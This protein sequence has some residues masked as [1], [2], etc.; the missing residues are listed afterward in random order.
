MTT[1]REIKTAFYEWFS[2]ETG[3]QNVFKI[4][5]DADFVAG[6]V[7]SGSFDSESISSLNFETDHQTTLEKLASKIQGLPSV[8]E[9][10]VTGSR[11]ITVTGFEKGNLIDV[12]GPIVTGGL[13]P[14]IATIEQVQAP[15]TIPVVFADQ[16]APRPQKPYGLIRLGV[17]QRV[18]LRDEMRGLDRFGVTEYV[19]HRMMTVTLDMFGDGAF[20]QMGQARGSLAKQLVLDR[21]FYTYGIAIIDDGNITNLTNYLEVISEER[22]RMEV[23]IGYSM[24]T[25]E[26]LGW[27]ETVEVNDRIVQIDS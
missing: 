20:E 4:T 2:L 5:F 6:N 18:G 11:E 9:A 27:I 8:F 24:T 12:T 10:K 13:T 26:D 21:F 1:F 19:G 17:E 16:A 23:R 25:K 15:L 7:V 22:A 14:P 3:L